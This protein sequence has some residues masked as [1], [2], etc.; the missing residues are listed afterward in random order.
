VN[1]GNA[2]AYLT[3]NGLHG[4]A[5]LVQEYDF[6]AL[7]RV[8]ASHAENTRKVQTQTVAR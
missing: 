6:T 3:R 5:L 2:A 8:Q 7:L 1:G 4:P